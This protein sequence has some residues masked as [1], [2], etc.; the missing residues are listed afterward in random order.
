MTEHEPIGYR[1]ELDPANRRMVTMT[2]PLHEWIT[3]RSALGDLAHR[4]ESFAS[5]TKNRMMKYQSLES[6]E[7]IR[8][9]DGKIKQGLTR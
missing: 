7:R 5:S 2:H 9:L 1:P 6:S 8:A 4:E 3:I